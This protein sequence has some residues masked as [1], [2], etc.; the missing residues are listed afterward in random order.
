[1]RCLENGI[2]FGCHQ[3]FPVSLGI[4]EGIIPF[5]ARTSQI[6]LHMYSFSLFFEILFPDLG[7]SLSQIETRH[8]WSV[9]HMGKTGGE[10]EC[11]LQIVQEVLVFN[12]VASS[13]D[14]D[15][16]FLVWCLGPR[17]G[18]AV[19]DNIWVKKKK[20]EIHDTE[21]SNRPI[22][23]LLWG[24][25]KFQQVD[26]LIVQTQLTSPKNYEQIN[27]NDWKKCLSITSS[28]LFFLLNKVFSTVWYHWFKLSYL[29]Q[30]FEN[31]AKNKGGGEANVAFSFLPHWY[32]MHVINHLTFHSK[33]TGF[34]LWDI[35]SWKEHDQLLIPVCHS[36]QLWIKISVIVCFL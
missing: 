1:M 25:L 3:N 10:R 29:L 21:K 24:N 33:Y 12:V 34:L 2:K 36:K 31:Y 17:N 18:R 14:E 19:K 5:F 13:H 35:D 16:S 7:Y 23:K 32:Q 11:H 28:L 27:D 30:L 15:H 26:L 6:L 8:T 4:V 22:T 20:Y 9:M